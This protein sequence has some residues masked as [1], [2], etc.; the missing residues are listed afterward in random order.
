MVID[1]Y[2]T[3]NETKVVPNHGAKTVAM[4]FEDESFAN[5]AFPNSYSLATEDNV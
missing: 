2:F 5:M 3:W 1:H 4:F